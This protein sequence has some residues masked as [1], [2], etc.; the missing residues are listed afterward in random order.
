MPW[1][2]PT[3][4]PL[5]A[6]CWPGTLAPD[7]A[8]TR[9]GYAFVLARA[10]RVGVVAAAPEAATAVLEE[11]RIWGYVG[12]PLTLDGSGWQPPSPSAALYFR[13]GSRVAALALA[14][15]LGLP[16]RSVV[17]AG[18]SPRRIVLVTGD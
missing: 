17:R 5:C 10:T 2:A 9:L 6:P 16:A 8:S 15:D 7:L 12:E 18:D 13:P 3:P 11:L 14:G 1:R 4:R